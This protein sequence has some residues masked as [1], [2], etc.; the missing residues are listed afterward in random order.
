MPETIDHDEL[1]REA[2]AIARIVGG[3]RLDGFTGHMASGDDPSQ[4]GWPPTLCIELALKLGTAREICE[5]HG[6][7]KAQWDAIRTNPHFIGDLGRAVEALRSEGVAFKARSQ[8][9]AIELLKTSWQLIH[10]HDT[11]ANVKADMIKATIRWAGLDASK[12]MTLAGVAGKAGGGF[13]ISIN[14][15]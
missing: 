11:P 12:D 15:G 4:I 7:D 6:I 8:L 1:N 10:A 3:H 5:S 2:T 9:Q 14:L 13:S